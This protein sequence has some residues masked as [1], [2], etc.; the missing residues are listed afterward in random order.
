MMKRTLLF[1]LAAIAVLAVLAYVVLQGPGEQSRSGSDMLVT[2]DSA[3]VVRMEFT[4][5]NGHVVLEKIDGIW[6][7]TEPL[8]YPAE[9]FMATRA[10]ATGKSLALKSVVS[11]NPEKQGLFEVDSTGTLVSI[12]TDRGL[13]AAFRIG[14]TTTSFTET[15]VRAEGSDD[16]Y[17]TDGLIHST[18]DKK[19]TDWRDKTIFQMPRDEIMQVRF[20]YGDTVFTVARSDTG[21]MVGSTPIGE[22]TSFLA[23]LSSFNTQS[24]IDSAV[25]SPPTRVATIEVGGA[26]IHFHEAPSGS[27]YLVLTSRS[28]QWFSVPVW[29]VK[30]LLLRKQNFE[31][32]K[33]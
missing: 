33:R 20:S 23:A 18:F 4:G 3:A 27:D 25:T 5:D 8:R 17:I 11:S 31:T 7:I 12:F 28:P 21:W 14:K 22:P 2:Y 19:G 10:V 24:F 1:S 26:A 13:A 16:V 30:Q 15:Y 6:T 9:E 29:K 32:M